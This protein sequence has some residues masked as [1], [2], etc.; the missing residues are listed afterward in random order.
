MARAIE[1]IHYVDFAGNLDETVCGRPAG[2]ELEAGRITVY[3]SGA[4]CPGCQRVI[5]AR[6]DQL[7]AGLPRPIAP[8]NVSRI[9]SSELPTLRSSVTP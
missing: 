6:L 8:S 1:A 2:P 5:A 9:A 4:T 3:L 7:S